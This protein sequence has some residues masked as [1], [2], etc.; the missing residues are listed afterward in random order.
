MIDIIYSLTL[1]V[2]D[3]RTK[4][5]K[6]AHSHLLLYTYTKRARS[7]DTKHNSTQTHAIRK[8]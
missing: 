8:Y 4:K 7:Q 2:G 6:K 1:Y 3:A 5:K